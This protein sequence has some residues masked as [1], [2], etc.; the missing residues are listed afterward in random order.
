MV[1]RR[2]GEEGRY[3]S[4]LLSLA[5]RGGSSVP[6]SPLGD[7]LAGC[8]LLTWG[9][10]ISVQMWQGSVDR[11]RE[12]MRFYFSSTL[13]SWWQGCWAEGHGMVKVGWGDPPLA[14]GGTRVNWPDVETHLF[15]TTVAEVRVKMWVNAP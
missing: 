1:G 12:T 11:Q 9:A 14:A 8:A 4:C 13:G 15:V 6:Y 5:K 3:W 2:K 7:C 10:A